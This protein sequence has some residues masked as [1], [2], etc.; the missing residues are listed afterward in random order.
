MLKKWI[1]SA[2]LSAALISFWNATGYAD[3]FTVYPSDDASPFFTHPRLNSLSGH[4]LEMGIQTRR[5]A[6][7]FPGRQ[8]Y[9]KFDLSTISPGAVKKATLRLYVMRPVLVQGKADLY[10]VTGEWKE[11]GI[12]ANNLPAIQ[13]VPFQ[14]ITVFSGDMNSYF[15][16]DIT[17]QVQAWLADPAS[18]NGIA[19]LP[20][21]TNVVSFG[22]NAKENSLTSHPVELEV[23]I[24]TPG[25]P[26]PAGLQGPQGIAILANHKAHVGGIGYLQNQPAILF[27]HR[28]NGS[29]KIHFYQDRFHRLFA[30]F[31]YRGEFFLRYMVKL[32]KCFLL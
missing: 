3:T 1:R 13:A 2:V 27:E 29:A 31:S 9:I 11:E 32:H 21:P 22:I 18:N 7:R 20:N 5:P 24:D 16:L 23:T 4:L 25:T 14:T 12:F 17:P 30:K 19:I 6:S 15:S 10:L 8:A 26:G 28:N